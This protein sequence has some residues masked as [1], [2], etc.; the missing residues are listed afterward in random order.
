MHWTPKVALVPLFVLAVAGCSDSPER[1]DARAGDRLGDASSGRLSARPRQ[2]VDE[3]APTGRRTLGHG[4]ELYVPPTYDANRRAGLVLTLHGAGGVPD[5]GLGPLL[6]LADDGELILLSPKSRDSTWDVL[7]SGYGPDVAVI[8][9]LLGDVF[10]RYAVDPER[11]Y[12]SGF[13]DGASYALSLGLTNGELFDAIVAFSPG[14]AAPG[15]REGKPRVFVSHGTDDAI[16]S[17]DRTSRVLVPELR[18]AGYDVEYREFRGPHT[19]PS[20]IAREAV[21]WLAE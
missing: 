17:I 6:P 20:E 5:H 9:D 13:S 15:R 4:A 14:F 8:D 3:G 19:V 12:V 7:F 16:L 10:A 11:V 2:R 1:P 21:A 18:R